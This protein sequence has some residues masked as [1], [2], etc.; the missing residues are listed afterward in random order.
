LFITL[1]NNFSS[2]SFFQLQELDALL[3]VN[4][5]THKLLSEHLALDDYDAMMEEANHN[6]VAP[7][8]KL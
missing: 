3:R 5:L 2:L 6:V 4:K 1:K 7:Y 8:G